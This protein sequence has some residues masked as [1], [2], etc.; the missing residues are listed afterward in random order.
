VNESRR[1]LLAIFPALMHAAYMP[2]RPPTPANEFA[3]LY[4][5]WAHLMNGTPEGTVNAQAVR[6]WARVKKAWRELE[7]SV[8]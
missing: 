4:N 8:G 2:E 6:Q 7:K 3:Q 5:E 1:F